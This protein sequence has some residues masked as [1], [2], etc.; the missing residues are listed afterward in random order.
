MKKIKKQLAEAMNKR[1]KIAQKI[2]KEKED[3]AKAQEDVAKAKRDKR[4]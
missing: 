2:A 3:L 1:P 4:Y